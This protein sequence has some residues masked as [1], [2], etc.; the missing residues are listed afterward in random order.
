MSI[1]S[2]T[3][4]SVMKRGILVIAFCFVL[5]GIGS[6]PALGAVNRQHTPRVPLTVPEKTYKIP[7]PGSISISPGSAFN[8]PFPDSPFTVNIT[9]PENVFVGQPFTIGTSITGTSDISNPE[10]GTW[11]FYQQMLIPSGVTGPTAWAEHFVCCE[12]A[13]YPGDAAGAVTA[14]QVDWF[15]D[16]LW[17]AEGPGLVPNMAGGLLVAPEAA[18]HAMG[19]W[20][21][22]QDRDQANWGF[23]N[24]VI[25]EPGDYT[26]ELF[27]AN[28]IYYDWTGRGDWGADYEPLSFTIH[29]VNPVIPA[30]I[31]IKPETINLKAKGNWIT[32]W[33]EVPGHDAADIDV[34]TVRLAGVAA[35]FAGKEIADR[36]GDGIK[37]LSVRFPRIAVSAV[38]SGEGHILVP[39]TGKVGSISFTGAGDVRVIH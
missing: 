22:L 26:F 35:D 18:G 5:I 6:T 31:E 38:L 1:N 28:S 27:F 34:S 29:A 23:S 2:L 20:V 36:D 39:V 16:Y 14:R 17:Y 33:I 21:W 32:A 24:M 15:N 25:D 8:Y 10:W 19:P 3:K 7:V 13:D 37:E 4:G 9:V 30:N 11:L 12:N